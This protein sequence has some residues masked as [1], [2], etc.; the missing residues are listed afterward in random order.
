M[1]NLVAL[2]GQD[3]LVLQGTVIQG[4]ADGTVVEVSFPNEIATVKTGKN[5]N[6]LY[7]YNAAGAQADL[8]IRVIRGSQDDKTLNNL[9]IQQNSNFAGD[10]LISGTFTKKIGDNAG[11]IWNDQYILSFGIFTKNIAAKSNVDGDVEQ[12]VA[13][14]N[15]RF[16]SAVRVIA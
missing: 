7:A 14:Y 1:A 6:S 5:G 15:L 9:I 10:T 16:A 8:K 12:A 4:L 11:D 2:S 3:T 13:E